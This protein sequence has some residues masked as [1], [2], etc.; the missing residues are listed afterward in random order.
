MVKIFSLTLVM[1]IGFL[2]PSFADELK[3]DIQTMNASQAVTKDSK[4]QRGPALAVLKNGDLLLGGGAKGGTI[5]LG[6]GRE[7]KLIE[8]GN[9]IATVKRKN[10]SRFAITDIAI[11]SENKKNI[12]ALVSYPQLGANGNC[13]EVVVAE[14]S[15]DLGKKNLAKKS[16]WFT[17]K[18]CVPISAV[19]HA[20]GRMEKINSTS[21]YLTIGDLGFT[22]IDETK[23]RQDL[24]S[25]FMITANSVKKISTGHRNA[26][27]IVL[28]NNKTL[29]ISEHGPRGGDEIN[30]ITQ[31][32]DY[33]WPF[34]TYGKAYSSG[35]Y[36]K[37]KKPGTHEGFTKPIKYWVPSI[38]PTELVQ[39]PNSWGI[40][41]GSLVM[42]TLKEE[43]L[44]FMKVDNNN[45]IT[46]EKRIK[47]NERIRD[48]DI[49]KTG[50]IV[51]TTD[52]GKIIVFKFK[53]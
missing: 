16:T 37:P 51:G 47:V 34:V 33:G 4:G 3:I 20:S 14:V 45:K 6:D 25:V 18:P 50:S 8:L 52:S 30:V 44:V 36:I 5:F 32:K 1:I 38:A 40:W 9:L 12:K 21:A 11:L 29:M 24:G 17:S 7:R 43:S 35:D 46:S 10:D 27:G 49:D 39:L 2:N 48:L 42:G 41:S 19:Q 26:Q 22:K 28:F 13:V 23:T 15:I 31:D 53:V